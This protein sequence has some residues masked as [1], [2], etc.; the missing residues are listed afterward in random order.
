MS[1]GALFSFATAACRETA[2]TNVR[3][4]EVYLA[5]RVEVDEDAKA[6]GVTSASEFAGV[7]ETILD[8][9]EIRSSR[10]WVEKVEDLRNVR[11]T[12]KF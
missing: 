5:L 12:R 3:F 10:V 1:Q 9:E 11:F 8:R 6:H 2:E 7:Y 4:N